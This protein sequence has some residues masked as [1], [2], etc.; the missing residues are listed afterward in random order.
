MERPTS[1]GVGFDEV[2]RSCREDRAR[3]MRV[4]VRQ[5]EQ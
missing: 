5:A 1:I 3:G 2:G 4:T